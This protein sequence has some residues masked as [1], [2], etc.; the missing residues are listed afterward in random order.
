MGYGE[1]CAWCSHNVIASSTTTRVP[2]IHSNQ[3]STELTVYRIVHKRD[4]VG[5][6]SFA[7]FSSLRAGCGEGISMVGTSVCTGNGVTVGKAGACVDADVGGTGVLVGSGIAVGGEGVLVSSGMA[8]GGAGILV[9]SGIAI[10]GK[11]VLVG[12]G[13]ASVPVGSGITAGSIAVSVGTNVASGR[14]LDSSTETI[15]GCSVSTDGE[16][17]ATASGLAVGGAGAPAEQAKVCKGTA[18]ASKICLSVVTIA[19]SWGIGSPVVGG[20]SIARTVGSGDCC[21]TAP[22]TV[23]GKA[24]GVSIEG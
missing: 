17:I 10:G 20:A 18:L 16:A 21:G 11:D 1:R 7:V 8:M 24:V 19:D 15:R 6:T 3:G 2:S 13:S 12:S 4:R 22:S 9:D 5:S 14:V 23:N